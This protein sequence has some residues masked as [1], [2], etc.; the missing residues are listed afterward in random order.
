[1]VFQAAP[2][3]LAFPPRTYTRSSSPPFMLHAP[4]NLILL[5]IILSPLLFSVQI[6]SS[7]P[8]SQK[9]SVYVPPLMSETKFHLTTLS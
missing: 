4:H 5:S 8:C 6:S 1:L 9:P 3:L 7:A 2:F